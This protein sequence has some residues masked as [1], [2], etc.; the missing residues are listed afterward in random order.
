MRV[1]PKCGQE[2]ELYRVII[3]ADI[4]EDIFID[5]VTEDGEINYSVADPE[6]IEHAETVTV[7]YMC[8]YCQHEYMGDNVNDIYFKEMVKKGEEEK[9]D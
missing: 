6:I 2:D 5:E 8:S 7:T 1:C 9:W 3:N 4:F